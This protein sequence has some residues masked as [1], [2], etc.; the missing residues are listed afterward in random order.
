MPQPRSTTQAPA[1]RE[2]RGFS[3]LEMLFATT[4]LLV[5]LV[6]VAQLVPA[7]LLLNQSNRTN[8][9]ALV[10]VQHELDL[11]VNQPLTSSFYLDPVTSYSYNLG[12]PAQP[13]QLVGS[14]VATVNNR[15]VIDF[16]QSTVP[17]YNLTYTDTS[18]PT[19]ATWDLRWAV[20]TMTYNASATVMN[21]RFIVG[22]RQ[23]G[24]Q[25]FVLPVTLDTMV[26]K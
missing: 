23:I 15:T 16:S 10:V 18:D 21:K 1:G 2:Q 3:L 7:S 12:D 26:S 24:G 22:A 14:P 25:G 11:L 19:G 17:G 5:G 9:S 8:S 20:I 4:V 6:G 13:G